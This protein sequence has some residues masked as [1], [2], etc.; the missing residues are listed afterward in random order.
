[1]RRLLTISVVAIASALIDY[2][3][4][5]LSMAVRTLPPAHHAAWMS[6]LEGACTSRVQFD[7]VN[8]A[9]QWYGGPVVVGVTGFIVGTIARVFRTPWS[10]LLVGVTV[11]AV[12]MGTLGGGVDAPS[13]FS[14]FFALV[15]A[16]GGGTFGD[17]AVSGYRR[18]IPPHD[19]AL[20]ESGSLGAGPGH[21]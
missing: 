4:S 19:I 8:A 15:C 1:M 17:M 3:V 18:Q 6:L 10:S 16:T 11:F 5:A 2:C 14:L 20:P 12:V 7:A 21:D 9:M 13:V